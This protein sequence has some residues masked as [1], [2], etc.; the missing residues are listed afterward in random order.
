MTL[1]ERTPQALAA[2]APKAQASSELGITIGKL[3]PELASKLGLKENIGLVVKEV[4]SDGPGAAMGLR[5]GDVI[6]EVD[7]SV[8]S[9]V[10]EFNKKVE[11]SK[12]SGVIRMMIQRGSATIFL[13]ESF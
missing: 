9:G 1:A 6:L 11:E 2:E 3:P 8:I 7:G 5:Q 13:A 12:K 10:S 4:N